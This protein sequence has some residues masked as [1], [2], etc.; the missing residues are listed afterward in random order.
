MRRYVIGVMGAVLVL[1]MVS[2]AEG[3][4]LDYKVLEIDFTDPADAAAQ[5]SWTPADELT[6]TDE[7]LGW[8]G[9]SASSWDGR[10]HTVTMAQGLSWRPASSVSVRVHLQPPMKGFTLND[11]STSVPYGGNVFVR[12]SPDK[13]HWS[14]WQVLESEQKPEE[15][16]RHYSG[17]VQVPGVARAE[18]Q[19][20]LEQYGARDVPWVSDEEA[21]VRWI[22]GEDPDFFEKNL[23]FI[24]YIELLYE[25]SFYGGQRLQS[26]KIE[27]SCAISGR[28]IPPDDPTAA[29]GRDSIPWRFEAAQQ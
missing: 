18:Y 25:G 15:P 21:A 28:H 8:D 23:P 11:G 12:Y 1:L 17:V 10:I 4:I 6:V 27:V 3:T 24:G 9:E 29:K 20:R 19:R 26:M 22:V 16:G 5:A 2:G 7:G 13:Q 14:S